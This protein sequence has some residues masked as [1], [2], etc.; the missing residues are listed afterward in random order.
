VYV[1]LK[2][3]DTDDQFY[4]LL[5][6]ALVKI[7]PDLATELLGKI[8]LVRQLKASDSS[9]HQLLYFDYSPT[10]FGL[11]PDDDEDR[12]IADWV[13]GLLNEAG[14]F[15]GDC[16]ELGILHEAPEIPE[17]H[18]ARLDLSLLV[19]CTD[20]VKWEGRA[21]SGASW[22]T[23]AIPVKVLESILDEKGR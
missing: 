21:K 16:I 18:Q 17:S 9:V 3:W 14:E 13:E 15:R 2:V 7:T 4:H 10:V 20:E 12:S 22:D 5:D 19:V 8:A 11:Y 6:H 1:L 23:A